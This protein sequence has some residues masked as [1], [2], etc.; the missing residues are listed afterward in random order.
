MIKIQ[1]V[2]KIYKPSKKVI[3]K[4]LD[5]ISLEIPQGSITAII[6]QTGSGKST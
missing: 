2:S 6:G 1:N 3:I 5:N 4:A